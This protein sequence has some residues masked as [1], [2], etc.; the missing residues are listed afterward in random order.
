[1]ITKF[2]AVTIQF[3]DMANDSIIVSSFEDVG[4]YIKENYSGDVITSIILEPVPFYKRVMES[5]D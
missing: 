1:M 3:P 4:S 5:K 2:L